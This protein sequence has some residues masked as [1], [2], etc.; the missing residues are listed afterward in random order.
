[1]QVEN[2]YLLGNFGVDLG[3]RSLV[4]EPKRIHTGDWT[5]QA[6]PFYPG[7]MIYETTLDAA[8]PKDFGRVVLTLGRLE[9]VCA[10]V[11][12]G[13]RAAGRVPWR[14]ADGVDIGPYL[15]KG[16]NRIEIELAGSPRNLLGPLHFAGA[17]PAR[18]GPWHFAPDDHAATKDYV[19]EPRGLMNDVRVEFH[20]S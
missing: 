11:R 15:E 19:L 6:W 8:D 14:T 17:K 18:T 12:V 4:T 3:T 9:A 16:A 10:E 13:G 7:N 1:M 5:L 2:M 20:R